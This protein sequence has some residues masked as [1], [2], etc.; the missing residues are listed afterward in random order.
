MTKNIITV[1]HY[2]PLQVTM[3][4]NNVAKLFAFQ[5]VGL[6][7]SLLDQVCPQNFEAL[8]FKLNS[9]YP[10]LDNFSPETSKCFVLKNFW[11]FENIKFLKDFHSDHHNWLPQKIDPKMPFFVQI[12]SGNFKML[13]LIKLGTKDIQRWWL[14]IW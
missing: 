13:F 7:I 14:C 2:D 3:A 6:K 12:W 4:Q 11:I 10:F 5:N 8:R 1:S 9:V